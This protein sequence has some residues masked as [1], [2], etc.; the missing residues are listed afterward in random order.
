MSRQD[1]LYRR[2]LREDD[3][4]LLARV[5]TET[6]E[7][8]PTRQPYSAMYIVVMRCAGVR[9]LRA[10]LALDSEVLGDKQAQANAL[11][12]ALLHQ[13]PEAAA[14]LIDHGVT[15]QE[16][17]RVYLLAHV[18]D[19]LALNG[20]RAE[21]TDGAL[22]MLPLYVAARAVFDDNAGT[23]LIRAALFAAEPRLVEALLAL[24]ADPRLGDPSVSERFEEMR[25]RRVTT[26][27]RTIAF[28]TLAAL[29]RL[30]C[31]TKQL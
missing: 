27:G 19:M 25:R 9:C 17:H 14:V 15:L 28:E 13:R 21:H 8:I 16:V 24:G 30:L 2:A 18:A 26:A 10:L 20:W 3:G 12:Y 1:G 5:L 29:E 11:R 31:K 6:P 23:K 22:K 4:E 7:R